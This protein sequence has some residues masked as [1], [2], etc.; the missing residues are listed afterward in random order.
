MSRR[1]GLSRG[2]LGELLEIRIY[3]YIDCQT[4]EV[5]LYPGGN[6]EALKVVSQGSS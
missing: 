6:W 4:K 1:S 3:I 5:E 2:P